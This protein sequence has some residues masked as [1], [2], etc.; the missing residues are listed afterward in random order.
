MADRCLMRHACVKLAFM[1]P[2]GSHSLSHK[3]NR[4][5][6]TGATDIRPD[7]KRNMNRTGWHA[8]RG[9][10]VTH[11]ARAKCC[12]AATENAARLLPFPPPSI[13]VLNRVDL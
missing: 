7:H 9:L 4:G 10:H 3:C 8:V 6:C 1:L 13:A 2:K 12:C 5:I 11:F